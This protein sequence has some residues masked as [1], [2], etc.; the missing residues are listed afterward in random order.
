MTARRRGEVQAARMG[1]NPDKDERRFCHD[2][3]RAHKPIKP[4][5][6]RWPS[7]GLQQLGSRKSRSVVVTFE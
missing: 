4:R 7:P 2:T 3:P 1:P 6:N 5:A